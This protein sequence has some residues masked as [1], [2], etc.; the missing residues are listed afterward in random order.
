[1]NQ[2]ATWEVDIPEGYAISETSTD[3]A[4]TPDG[5]IWRLDGGSDAWYDNTPIFWAIE[6]SRFTTHYAP[7]YLRKVTQLPEGWE[8]RL[9]DVEVCGP[10]FA[11]YSAGVNFS[12]MGNSSGCD[13]YSRKKN[14]TLAELQQVEQA[15]KERQS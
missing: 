12:W 9:H 1:M 3:T 15:V 5:R 2:R 10:I 8:W 7:I 11:Y 14:Y 13:C 6:N 4:I